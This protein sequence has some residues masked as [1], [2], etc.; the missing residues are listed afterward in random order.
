M[1]APYPHLKGQEVKE[2]LQEFPTLAAS[3]A[4][5]AALPELRLEPTASDVLGFLRGQRMSDPRP[6]LVIG[7]DACLM[8]LEEYVGWW[9]SGQLPGAPEGDDGCCPTL[10]GESHYHCP[11]C[12]T[13]CPQVGHTT[14]RDC[15]A[16]R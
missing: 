6:D 2:M 3:R 13:I 7:W 1:A 4:L 10:G 11:R 15:E 9:R 12:G 16:A 8:A 14:W 5:Q